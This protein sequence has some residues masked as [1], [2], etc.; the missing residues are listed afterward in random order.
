M[1]DT[2]TIAQ[3]RAA[4]AGIPAFAGDYTLAGDYTNVIEVRVRPEFQRL[5]FVTRF[6]EQQLTDEQRALVKANNVLEKRHELLKAESKRLTDRLRHIRH[7][8]RTRKPN[9]P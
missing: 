4:L 7:T 1:S 9:L 5:Q 6:D 2:M 8:A 3:L